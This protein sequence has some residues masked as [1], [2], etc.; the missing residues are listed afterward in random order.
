MRCI[1]NGE[2]TTTGEGCAIIQDQRSELVLA[3]REAELD[4][5]D[6]CPS[7]RPV[8][9]AAEED[10]MSIVLSHGDR[11]RIEVEAD[12]ITPFGGRMVVDH[13]Y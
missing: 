3:T 11:I 9:G 12:P 6:S 5:Q 1:A 7:A 13:I 4:L 8:G 2:P 10:Q